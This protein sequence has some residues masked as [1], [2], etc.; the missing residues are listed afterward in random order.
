MCVVTYSAWGIY[1][2]GRQMTTNKPQVDITQEMRSRYGGLEAANKSLGDSIATFNA[3]GAEKRSVSPVLN[4][5]LAARPAGVWY[6]SINITEMDTQIE[7]I[8]GNVQAIESL[9]S[10]LKA[11]RGMESAAAASQDQTGQ[12]IRFKIQT[13][14]RHQ[15]KVKR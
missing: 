4:G 3:I 1:N 10:D 7:G 12:L 15:N 9:V 14:P 8:T 11:T 2:S 13:A 6:Q 5:I